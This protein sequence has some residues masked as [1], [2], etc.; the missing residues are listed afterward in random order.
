[1]RRRSIPAVAV[2]LVPLALALCPRS[3]LSAEIPAKPTLVFRF[4][5]GLGYQAIGDI[6]DG[7]KGFSDA[8]IREM[9][10]GAAGGGYAPEHYGLDVGGD[11]LFQFGRHFGVGIGTGFLRGKRVSHLTITPADPA[12][13]N[14][15]FTFSPSV[16][17]VPLR[18]SA[19]AFIPLGR[20]FRI[21]INAGPE[22]YLASATTMILDNYPG[23]WWN[24]RES[25]VKGSGIGLHGGVGFEVDLSEGLAFILEGQGRL[26]KIDN[27]TGTRRY[28]NSLGYEESEEGTL[29]YWTDLWTFTPVPTVGIH[30]GPPSDPW[31]RNPRRAALDLTGWSVVAGFV[32]RL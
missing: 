22:G 17:V 23:W 14:E 15:V 29:Y 27:L 28:W 32:V 7:L 5:G 12:H 8:A 20:N 6:N 10:L 19:F 25:K 26:A 9:G 31:V 30:D 1:M 11:I 2:W 18:L 13:H 21:S 3:G 4:F 16:S 24:Q